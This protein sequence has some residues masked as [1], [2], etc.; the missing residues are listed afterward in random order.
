MITSNQFDH[1]RFCTQSLP[2]MFL[3]HTQSLPHGNVCL[4][5]HLDPQYVEVA[6]QIREP[7]SAF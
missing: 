1:L 2:F 6:L 5:I 7:L 3:Y 4:C